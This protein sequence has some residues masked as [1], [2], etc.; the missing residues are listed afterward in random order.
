[1]TPEQKR[2]VRY[3]EAMGYTFQVGR[4]MSD[5]NL[6]LGEPGTCHLARRHGKPDDTLVLWDQ[7]VGMSV[8]REFHPL[9]DANDALELAE[10]MGIEFQRWLDGTCYANA[11][12]ASDYGIDKPHDTLPAASCAA[13]DTA[14]D[15]KTM[16]THVPSTD[17]RI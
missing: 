4:E 16:S 11:E 17:P 15:N 2:L 9:T 3:A 8:N 7:G 12:N 5:R 6:I 1:M 10:K 14:L 13:V